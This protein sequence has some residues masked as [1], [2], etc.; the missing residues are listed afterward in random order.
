MIESLMIES[1]GVVI[2]LVLLV[3]HY[4]LLIGIFMRLGRMGGKAPGYLGRPCPYCT[5]IIKKSARV[6]PHCTRDVPQEGEW[7][8]RQ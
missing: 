6:C 5:E 2:G 3:L 8:G 4:A 1:L 7:K